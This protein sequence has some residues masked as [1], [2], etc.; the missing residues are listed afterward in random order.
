M[1]GSGFI[2]RSRG[3]L[4]PPSAG[5]ETVPLAVF[6]GVVLAALALA[7][8]FRLAR[9]DLRPMHHDEANQAVKFGE[10]LETGDYRYDR[11]DHHGPTLYYLTLPVAWLRGQHTLAS[12]DERTLRAVPAVFGAG[13]LLL[14]LPLVRGFGRPAIA[15]AA[16]LAAVSPALTF[17]SRFYIQES[18]LAFFTM[19]CL[20]ALGRYG[21]RPAPWGRGRVRG[22]RGAGV[23]HQG[24]LGDRGAGGA[25]GRGGGAP[26]DAG[27]RAEDGSEAA[28]DSRGWPPAPS[29][30][31]RSSRGR[32]GVAVLLRAAG[33][34]GRAPRVGP[35][36]R[37]LVDRGTPPARMRSRGTTISACSRGPRRAV[38][39][40]PKPWCSP[41]PSP[42]WWRPPSPGTYWQ[43]AWASTR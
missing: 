7:L 12:L 2:T 40:T 15:A 27:R 4:R 43:R 25:G 30:R 24:N 19:A 35:R 26:D 6:G 5:D 22:L 8:A 39:S 16:L 32:G 33:A 13:L 21:E 10:L 31:G 23:R 42:A 3:R 17:Y 41:S 29:G 11:H 14:F 1:T 37:H 9:T 36:L 18:I 28:R 34:P 38:S 20:V